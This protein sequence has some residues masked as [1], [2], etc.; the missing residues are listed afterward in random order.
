V[1]GT[2]IGTASRWHGRR[3][4]LAFD[5]SPAI[6]T[7]ESLTTDGDVTTIMFGTFGP[8][9]ATPHETA[10]LVM[11]RVREGFLGQMRWGPVTWTP[12][13]GKPAGARHTI[14]DTAVQLGPL[15]RR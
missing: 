5:T 3:A 4:E 10:E 9:P 13:D 8:N 12:I 2:F 11:R 1:S 14:P 6:F 7:F 15:V